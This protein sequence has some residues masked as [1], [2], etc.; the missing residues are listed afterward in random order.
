MADTEGYGLVVW[1]GMNLK[2]LESKYFDPEESATHFTVAG[3]QFTVPDGIL[4]MDITVDEPNPSKRLLYFRPL[5]SFYMS[6]VNVANLQ[7]NL[8]T[9]SAISYRTNRNKM[10]SQS[11]AQA[12]SKRGILFFSST[13]DESIICWNRHKPFDLKNTVCIL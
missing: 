5:A 1:N 3:T 11:A 8:A 6:Y 9:P 4:G 2:R 13:S 10:R 12:F 7:W